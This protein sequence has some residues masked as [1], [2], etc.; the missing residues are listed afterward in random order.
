MVFFKK[1]KIILEKHSLVNI[2]TVMKLINFIFFVGISVLVH[3]S[4]GWD[5]TTQI[6][7][8]SMLIA[9][10]YYRT[11]EG[12][13]MLVQRQWI[14]F[15]HKFADRSG[16]LNGDENERSPVFLQFLDCVYQ[17]WMKNPDAFEFNRRYLVSLL[18][19]KKRFIC[20][21]FILTYLDEISATHLFRIIF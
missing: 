1:L 19:L 5:R 3:C 11:F 16:V 8:L 14:E 13:E 15:G 10:S 7:S 17:L 12:F 21:I 9:D 6:V 4:D 2:R 20:K 18:F